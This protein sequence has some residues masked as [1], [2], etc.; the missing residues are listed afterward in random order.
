MHF[1]ACAGEERTVE[2][3][4]RCR[5][6]C[7]P[8]RWQ[9]G[10]GGIHKPSFIKQH[11][12]EIWLFSASSLHDMLCTSSVC[13]LAALPCFNTCALFT[14]STL[15]SHCA[16]V[17]CCSAFLCLLCLS[18]K[19]VASTCIVFSAFAHP[20]SCWQAAS[21]A[22]GAAK[23]VQN[24]AGNPLQGLNKVCCLPLTLFVYLRQVFPLYLVI[25][26]V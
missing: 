24:K 19:H 25:S 1:C 21:K 20:C 14:Q 8:V 18:W 7:W 11:R 16:N 22:K 4:E 13:Q 2:G 17:A 15:C 6:L 3:T 5:R 23:D 26:C 10:R 12:P 9:Q